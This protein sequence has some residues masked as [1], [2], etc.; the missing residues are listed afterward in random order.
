MIMMDIHW[1]LIQK[2]RASEYLFSLIWSWGWHKHSPPLWQ[3][4]CQSSVW[5]LQFCGF[6]SLTH[7]HTDQKQFRG[8]TNQYVDH[9][10]QHLDTNC[11]QSEYDRHMTPWSI[12]IRVLRNP[13]PTAIWSF[14]ITVDMNLLDLSCHQ[15]GCSPERTSMAPPTAFIARLATHSRNNAREPPKKSGCKAT[16]ANSSSVNHPRVGE[17]MRIRT[18]LSEYP[19]LDLVRTPDVGSHQFFGCEPPSSEDFRA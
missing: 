6:S 7:T 11:K 12:T 4:K 3:K 9:Q 16:A 17:L 10:Q 13:C 14:C 2:K 15:W 19:Q 5:S 8:W 18:W 1:Q